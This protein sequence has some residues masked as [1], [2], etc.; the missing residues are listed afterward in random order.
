M[1]LQTPNIFRRAGSLKRYQTLNPGPLSHELT[2]LTTRPRRN[3][4][5]YVKST[6]FVCAVLN[7]H[8]NVRKLT[9]FHKSSFYKSEITK[10]IQFAMGCFCCCCPCSQF[11]NQTCCSR[12]KKFFFTKFESYQVLKYSTELSPAEKKTMKMSEPGFFFFQKH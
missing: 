10:F 2:L 6:I 4:L 9:N 1:S 5:V 3:M 8:Y 12:M 7:T 11:S